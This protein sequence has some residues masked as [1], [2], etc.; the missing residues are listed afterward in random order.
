MAPIPVKK[1]R[2]IRENTSEIGSGNKQAKT[3]TEFGK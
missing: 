3:G 2:W 1:Q